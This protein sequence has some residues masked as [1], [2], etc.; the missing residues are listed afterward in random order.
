MTQIT[1]N[2]IRPTI[3]KST[4]R[5]LYKTINENVSRASGYGSYYGKFSSV[6][7]NLDRMKLNNLPTNDVLPGYTF[8]TRPKLN[9]TTTA[10]RHNR[11]LSM[12]DTDNPDSI[13]F[14]IRCLLDTT[15]AK[16]SDIIDKVIRSPFL[17]H[18]SPFLTP[19]CNSLV[20]SGGWPTPVLEVETTPSGFYGEDMTYAG[21]TDKLSKT[22]DLDLTFREM[23]GG[24][25]M[26]LLHTWFLCMDLLASGY[27]TPYPKYIYE[28]KMCYDVSIYRFIL[29]PS[30]R[31]IMAWARATGCFPK[32]IPIGAIFDENESEFYVS[33][34]QKY[35][36][37]FVANKVEYNDPILLLEFNM[38]MERYF[39]RLRNVKG[40]LGLMNVR[41]RGNTNYIGLPYIDLE[42]GNNEIN[43][44]ATEAEL[45]DPSADILNGL[46][47]NIREAEKLTGD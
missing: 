14:M 7:K 37:P 1:Y 25:V 31:S 34:M 46:I 39:P 23:P 44:Y 22:Y 21:G 36:V 35:S 9:L 45:Y 20:A 19:L 30:R 38:L 24:I 15:Y 8:I 3:P 17:N 6:L 26:S 29:D 32:S 42:G 47:N 18:N 40:D 43:F 41:D 10:I 27:L 2:D 33:S 4:I 12:L 28:G 13:Q 11:V 16:R 5:S